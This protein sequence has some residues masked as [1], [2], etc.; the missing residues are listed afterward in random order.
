M[1]VLKH[2]CKYSFTIYFNLLHLIADNFLCHPKWAEMRISACCLSSA[3]SSPLN[4][5]LLSKGFTSSY[6]LTWT[7]ANTVP[8]TAPFP[9]MQ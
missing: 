1:S 3:K 4:A 7:L 8:K 2:G 9:I 5:S 6:K